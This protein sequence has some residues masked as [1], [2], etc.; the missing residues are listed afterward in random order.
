MC[1]RKTLLNFTIQ[2]IHSQIYFLDSKI[3]TKIYNPKLFFQGH[4]CHFTHHHDVGLKTWGACLV[5]LGPK[6]FLSKD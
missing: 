2:N 5:M 3:Y 1:I 6:C 4:I